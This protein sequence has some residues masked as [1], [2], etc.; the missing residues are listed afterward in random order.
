MNPLCSFSLLRKIQMKINGWT[1]RDIE[2]PENAVRFF[3]EKG[4]KIFACQFRGLSQRDLFKKDPE[5]F[6]SQILYTYLKKM[7][8]L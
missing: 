7:K 4:D 2:Y 6:I 3:I 8:Y 1:I 5:K